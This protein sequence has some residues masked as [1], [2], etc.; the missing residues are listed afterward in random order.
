MDKLLLE[1]DNG[2]VPIDPKVAKKMNLEKGSLSP[3]TRERIL[4]KNGDFPPETAM[5]KD[6]KNSGKVESPA[7]NDIKDGGVMLTSSEVI[8]FAQGADSTDGQ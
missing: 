1:T 8:D 3:F 2:N 5:E 6:P 7:E 4:G